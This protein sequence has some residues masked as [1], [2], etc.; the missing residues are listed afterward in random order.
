MRCLPSGWIEVPLGAFTEDCKQ[1]V[2]S[3]G[4]DFTY[5][6]IGSIDRYSKQIVDAQVLSGENAPTRARKVVRTGD[7]LVSM[8][9]PNLNGVA[10]VPPHL[11]GQI[12][13]T[14]FDVLRCSQ[15]DPRWVFYI[16]RTAKFVDSMSALV[17]GALYPAVRSKEVR[18]YLS[19]LAPLNEQKR[20]ADK[21]DTIL[22][23]A[24]ACRSRLANVRSILDRF[25]QAVL[26]AALSGDLTAEWRTARGRTEAWGSL[27]LR[28]LGELGRGKSRHR[29]RNDP[30][31]FG[32][33]YPFV[34]TG[35]VANS[36]GRI[37]QHRQTYSE[38]GLRQSK[39]WPTGTLCITIAAN[40]ADTAILDY[41][42]CF[43]DS[44]VG[45]V[46]DPQRCLPTFIKWAIDVIK[47]DL[48]TFAP[49]TAQ[50]N[51][52]LSILD[53][54]K[55]QC[56]PLDEQTEIVRRV[57]SLFALA[58]SLERR[59]DCAREQ[60]ERHTP[61]LL[62]KAFRG[63]LVGQDLDD[64]PASALLASVRANGTQPVRRARRR[65]VHA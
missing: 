17:Q 13:S 46:A 47:R 7:V 51:I 29:P 39:L 55:V 19:P 59:L 58:D 24:D 18:A 22:A 20:I 25:R 31:L 12:A 48:E 41:P 8:T 42:A 62:A 26:K 43:P 52:N 45:F 3:A 5:I 36:G 2:P 56:P 53:Q 27:F 6:D 28:Q 40:I 49:A 16:V 57:D 14:G 4:R 1:C 32:G 34:Q 64:E 23:R 11:N 63:E 35:D 33:P 61:A 54:V 37:V 10:L 60:L 15:V 50:K 21:L 38:L 30:S 65:A 9:R 44:V